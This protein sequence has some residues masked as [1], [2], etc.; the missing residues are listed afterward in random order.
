MGDVF[1]D[2]EDDPDEGVGKAKSAYL[3]HAMQF[4]GV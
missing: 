1:N 3:L 2:D 4:L